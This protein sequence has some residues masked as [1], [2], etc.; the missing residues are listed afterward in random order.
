MDFNNHIFRIP[1]YRTT[2][3]KFNIEIE[4][5]ISRIV[6]PFHYK[7]CFGDD[8]ESRF[9]KVKNDR[10]NSINY[11]WEFNEITGYIGIFS[12]FKQI[13]GEK[14]HIFSPRSNKNTKNKIKWIGKLFEL[15]LNGSDS[16]EIIFTQLYDELKMQ[17]SSDNTLKGRY[18][19]LRLLEKTGNYIDWKSLISLR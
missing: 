11:L 9:E 7:Q 19:D 12:F 1:I 18:V 2:K 16:N 4:S 3:E 14:Y 13:R 15:N 6:D 8:W 5:D 17:C 10:K